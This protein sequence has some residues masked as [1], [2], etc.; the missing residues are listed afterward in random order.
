MD[1]FIVTADQWERLKELL[2]E[3][4]YSKLKPLEWED[5]FYEFNGLI[6]IRY[7]DCE[8]TPK[9]DALEAIYYEIYNQN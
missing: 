2:T 3:E 6:D 9:S 7:E 1:K 8:P 5:F 4:E